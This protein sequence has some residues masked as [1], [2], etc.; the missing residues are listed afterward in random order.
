L[1]DNRNPTATRRVA[2]LVLT[3]G[4]LALAALSVRPGPKAFLVRILDGVRGLGPWAPVIFVAIYAV[5]VILLIPGSALTLAAGA[6]FGVVEATACVS[7]GSTVGAAAAFLISRHFTRS[8]VARRFARIPVFT[9]IDNAVAN[10]GWRIVVLAR[11]CPVLPFTFLN[12]AFGLTRVRFLEYVL[13]SWAGML[14]G[15]FLFVYTGAALRAA[16][17]PR[18]R[19]PA[20]WLFLAIGLLSTGAIVAIVTRA[21]KPALAERL[22]KSTDSTPTNPP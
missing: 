16:A 14:P 3:A 7:A 12:Y 5:S 21:A 17:Q 13:A 2:L 19:T 4:I 1:I 10:E 9:A 11:L 8:T 22:K 20:E 6:L 15:T 18:A